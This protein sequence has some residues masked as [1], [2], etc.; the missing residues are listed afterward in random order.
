MNK[1]TKKYV[2]IGLGVLIILGLGMYYPKNN[3][4]IQQVTEYV[5]GNSNYIGDC[6]NN[7]G[8]EECYYRTPLNFASST[9][10]SIK[11]P[12]AT[13]T[14]LF[15]S[16]TLTTGTTTAFIIDIARAAKTNTTA[17]TTLLDATL[18]VPTTGLG[19]FLASTTPIANIIFAPGQYLIA[20]IAGASVLGDVSTLRGVCT[21]KFLI[22]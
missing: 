15:G 6:Y 1:N 9:I 20:K 22:N 7:N 5:G 4:V 2:L 10:C 8:V 11:S 14:L 17:T 3:P 19:T 12:L 13:S 16:V 21:A 18:N